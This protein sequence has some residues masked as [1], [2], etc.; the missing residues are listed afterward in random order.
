MDEIRELA[1]LAT[2]GQCWAYPGEPCAVPAGAGPDAC[3]LARIDRAARRGVIT[4]A[5]MAAVLASAGQ[6]LSPAAVELVLDDAREG[7]PGARPQ[8]PWYADRAAC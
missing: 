3:H 8:S 5:D 7:A 4:A 1:R 6:L 2:C